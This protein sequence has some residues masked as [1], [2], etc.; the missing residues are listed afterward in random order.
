MRMAERIEH[1]LTEALQASRVSVHDD[2]HRHRG[3]REAAP[4]GET[5]FRVEIVAARF[6]GLNAV[7]RHRLVYDTLAAELGDQ[8]HALQVTARTPE[9]AVARAS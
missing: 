3:H 6:A 2:S 8:V 1:K 9:E 7:E 5:H 4:G